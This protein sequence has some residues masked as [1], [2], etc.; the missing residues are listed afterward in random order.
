MNVMEYIESHRDAHLNELYEFLRI[1]SVSTKSEHKDDIE[2]A[3][4]WVADKLRAAGMETVEIVPTKMHPLVYAEAQTAPGKP[5]VL[6]YGHY[7]VQPP[8][9]LDLWTS[10]PFEPTV[11][12]GNL[13]G[14]GTADDKGQV[15]IHLKAL[16]SLNQALGKLPINVKALI[17][18]EEEVGSES[19]WEYVEKNKARLK[20]NAL[21]VS[22]T[23]MI[24]RGVP[25]I[26]YALRGLNYYQIAITGPAQDLH[27]GVFGGAVPNPLNILSELFAKL[28]DKNFHVT[29]PGFY[30]DVATLSR[31]ER[32]ALN[33]LPWKEKEFR[34]TVG[35]PA[36]CGE[37]GYSILEQ[38]WC[39]PTLDLNGIWGGYIGEGAKTVIPSVAHAKFSTRLVPNQDP[40]KIARLVEKHIRKLLPKAVQ[41]TFEVL[42]K[43][44]PWAAPYTH[45]VFQTAQ[46]ALEKGFGRRAVFIRE[47]GSIP[48]VT[49]MHDTFKV[50]CVLIG[51]GLPDEN[52]HA[53]DEHI[54]LENYFGGIKSIA[55]FY[56]ALA[57]L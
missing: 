40:D 39:R 10:P 19:L 34:K 26:T 25:S 1:P 49:Q 7:D 57:N 53:P 22:D 38:V 41:C 46:H 15:H 21:V 5:T 43:G 9:P 55:Q 24:T 6:F 42:S 51:F 4:K 44:K 17:E 8:E 23:S 13:Y 37:K 32:K 18:G 56:Q 14:R 48:F 12:G 45:P 52:A 2:R 35:A 47:G 20:A 50:P 3:A 29:I 27:S 11:R 30:D 31:A 28:H 54:A 36:L 16:E 33:S